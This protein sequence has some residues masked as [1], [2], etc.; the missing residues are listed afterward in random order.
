MPKFIKKLRIY[1]EQQQRCFYCLKLLPNPEINS[2]E[3][4][5][6]HVVPKCKAGKGK[7]LKNNIVV[8]CQDCN[9]RKG[10]KRINPSVIEE[11][12]KIFKVSIDENVFDVQYKLWN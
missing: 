6:D 2:K 11:R 12:R 8:S 1:L 9:L 5:L 10:S 7:H 3:T 4:T